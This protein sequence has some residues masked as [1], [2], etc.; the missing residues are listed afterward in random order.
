MKTEKGF[1][2]N[3]KRHIIYLF[4]GIKVAALQ[5]QQEGGKNSQTEN[6]EMRKMQKQDWRVWN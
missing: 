2:L 3:E 1:N 4:L 5:V 6:R